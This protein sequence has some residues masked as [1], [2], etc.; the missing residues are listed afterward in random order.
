[1]GMTATKTQPDK[2]IVQTNITRKQTTH[3]GTQ[4]REQGRGT[5]KKINHKQN[6]H[7]DKNNERHENKQNKKKTRI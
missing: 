2:Q 1:M 6:N 4:K 5:R 7:H 3:T